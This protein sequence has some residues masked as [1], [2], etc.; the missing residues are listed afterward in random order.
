MSCN[1]ENIFPF[2]TQFPANLLRLFLQNFPKN[3]LRSGDIKL[4]HT[5]STAL[6]EIRLP[7]N[8]VNVL[9]NNAFLTANGLKRLDL[10]ENKLSQITNLTFIGLSSL[11]YLDLSSNRIFAID[12]GSFAYLPDLIRLDLNS[13]KLTKLPNGLFAGLLSLQYLNLEMNQLGDVHVDVFSDCIQLVHLNFAMNPL[14]YIGKVT[15]NL[16]H[17]HYCDFSHCGLTRIPQNLPATIRD[18]RLSGNMLGVIER[19]ELN[20]YKALVILV[21]DDCNLTSLDGDSFEGT[22]W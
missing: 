9:R 12:P 4:F 2:P 19:K 7:R 8:S 15:L 10:S 22:G 5:N 6:R 13:N 3:D 11:L 18:I 1:G 14:K 17:L 21:L 16:P 20:T